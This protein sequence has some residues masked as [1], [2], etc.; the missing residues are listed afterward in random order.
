MTGPAITAD[1]T[2]L[3]PP[4]AGPAVDHRGDHRP[5]Q[6]AT[7]RRCIVTGDV[8]PIAQ[9]L[10]FAVD[11]DGNIVPDVAG[12]L[13]GRGLWLVPR[14]DM[15][16][17][18]FQ[19]GRFARAAGRQV[20]R[21]TDNGLALGVTVEAL[22]ARR[23]R[24]FLGLARRSGQAVM[25]FDQVHAWLRALPPTAAGAVLLQASDGAPGSRAR[26]TALADAVAPRV[27]RVDILSAAELAQAFGR[28]RVVHVGLGPHVGSARPAARLVAEANRLAGFRDGH[29]SS[30]PAAVG[31]DDDENALEGAGGVNG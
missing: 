24:E 23:C 5:A 13:P 29:E 17:Q 8:L 22:L 4:G 16:V 20:R 18:A 19:R 21:P 30:T 3:D 15:V 26:L 2:T 7:E 10:R 14:R 28:E 6:R 12:R 9:L 1:D 27:A 11:P 31:R 25:G